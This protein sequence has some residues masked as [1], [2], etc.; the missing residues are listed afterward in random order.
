MLESITAVQ[1]LFLG[2]VLAWAGGYKF[3]RRALVA[4]GDS[5]LARLVG[6]RRLTLTYRAVACVELATAAVL[7]APPAMRWELWLAVALAGGFLSYL[8]YTRIAAPTSSCGCMGSG[9]GRVGWRHFARAG[10]L[11]AAAAVAAWTG[12]GPITTLGLAVL[13]VELL[14]LLLLSPES[15]H[16]IHLQFGR[17]KERLRPHPLAAT[18]ELAQIP[19]QATL[20]RLY[21]SPVYAA[22]ASLLRS[23]VQDYW[24]VDDWRILAFAGRVGAEPA[25]TVVTV[26]FAVPA[27][28]A[29]ERIR[30]SIVDA[31][32]LPEP[33]LN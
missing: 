10:L 21:D 24:D 15:H 4:A 25:G 19:L 22:N 9:A 18:K 32:T 11:L 8:G 27:E 2:L 26:V 16:A 5:A 6:D 1:P 14:V 33:S 13:G 31:S 30:M 12:N 20:E 17:L 3:T 23:D 7:L 28:L 29:P